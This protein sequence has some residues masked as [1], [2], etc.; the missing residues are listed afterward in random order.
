MDISH[1]FQR[2]ILMSDK[3]IWHKPSLM[4]NPIIKLSHINWCHVA[5]IASIV[6]KFGMYDI[7]SLLYTCAKFKRNRRKTEEN[8]FLIIIFI[9]WC[10][11]TN[12]RYVVRQIGQHVW[13][14]E[15]HGEH[16][17]A[18]RMSLCWLV[19]KLWLVE[20]YLPLRWLWPWPWT[21][22]ET[23]SAVPTRG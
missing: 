7:W 8:Y 15:S 20:W 1:Q 18:K 12:K 9:F 14:S 6:T 17:D 21:D 5:N 3:V 22:A 11:V 19:Q 23:I 4:G 10:H 13:E 2:D 16:V